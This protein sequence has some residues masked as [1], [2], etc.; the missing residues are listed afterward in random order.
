M[1][2]PLRRAFLDANVLRGYLQTDVLLT[3]AD[4]G[5]FQPR[6]SAE[7][8]DEVRRNRPARL[9]EQAIARRLNQMNLAFPRSMVEAYEHLEP[10]MLADAK[11]KHV[12]AAAVH[13]KSTILVTENVKDFSPPA[14]GPHAMPVEKTS[15]F[16]NSLLNQN[17]RLVV[18][19]LHEMITRT[20]REPNTLSTLI[21]K[22]ASRNDLR[23][24]AQQLNSVLPPDHR[25]THPTLGRPPKTAHT[26][27]LDGIPPLTTPI[28][29]PRTPPPPRRPPHR[30]TP[31]TERNL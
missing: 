12:L 17:P 9:S 3:L 30:D 28:E 11:D 26:V 8:L 22:L 1:P 10:D 13:S 6:W 24:F 20:D 23:G 2:E 18:K 27:A 25:G 29:P 14:T 5:V 4:H 21:D 16:L 15:P 31:P 7:V 19:A